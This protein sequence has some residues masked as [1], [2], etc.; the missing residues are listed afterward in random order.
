M[1]GHNF[2]TSLKNWILAS[3]KYNLATALVYFS[4]R[5]NTKIKY[6][7]NLCKYNKGTCIFPFD[8]SIRRSDKYESSNPLKEI[9]NN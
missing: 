1:V 4:D 8:L 7:K 6:L 5:Q 9:T 3:N 2:S